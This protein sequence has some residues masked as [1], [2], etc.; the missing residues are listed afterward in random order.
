MST[1]SRD[2]QS[3]VNTV[4]CVECGSSSGLLW[5]GWCAYRTD[6][7]ELGEAPTLAFYCPTCAGRE[8]GRARR[9]DA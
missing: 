2:R 3:R 5:R 4:Q 6:D 1:H 8:F 9:G 7:P